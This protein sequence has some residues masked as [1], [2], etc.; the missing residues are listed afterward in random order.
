MNVGEQPKPL[1][2]GQR[3]FNNHARQLSE[4]RFQ[5]RVLLQ[6]FVVCQDVPNRAKPSVA[7]DEAARAVNPLDDHRDGD[8]SVFDDG[9]YQLLK[10]SSL[11]DSI[12]LPC[13]VR[14]LTSRFELQRDLVAPRVVGVEIDLSLGDLFVAN[15][16]LFPVDDHILTPFRVNVN[17][18]RGLILSLLP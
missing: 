9:F 15:L 5:V 17:S 18:A 2:L 7:V 4:I 8:S 14:I 6:D 16:E 3:T 11:L 13:F 10:S 1:F 12:C